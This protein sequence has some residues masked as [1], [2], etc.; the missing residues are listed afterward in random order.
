MPV[1]SAQAEWKGTLN[2]GGGTV[3]LGSGMFEGPYTFKSRVEEEAGTNPEELIAAAHAG[4]YSMF[5]S[6]RL[7]RAGYTPTRIHTTASVELVRGEAGLKITGIEL[8]TEGEIP[9]IGEAEYLELAQAAKEGCPVSAALS[10]VPITLKA[11][12]I[13]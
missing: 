13:S 5:L 10:A 9:G 7:S 4:C 2:D 11:T 1:R 8:V 6:A 3:K 12:L